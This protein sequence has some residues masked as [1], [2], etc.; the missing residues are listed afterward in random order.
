MTWFYLIFTIFISTGNTS[1]INVPLIT[2]KLYATA[3]VKK[4][5]K[6]RAR[7]CRCGG[8]R[9]PPAKPI[10]W[11]KTLYKSALSHAK[12]M[13]DYNF[14][15]HYSIEGKDIGQ[16]IEKFGYKWEVVGENLGEGQKNFDEVLNDWLES[17]S[18][19]KMLMNPKV[20]EMGVANY[21]RFWVQHFGKELP[22]NATPTRRK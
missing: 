7:G 9:M 2:N 18:H 22:K 14:F 21:G 15:A 10:Q 6:L 5:N 16:R 13:S 20:N 12:Q 8:K 4:V 11:N 3:I 17:S 19:C 1:S